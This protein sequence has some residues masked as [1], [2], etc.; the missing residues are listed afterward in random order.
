MEGQE[1]T[2]V[3]AGVM[4][5]DV[6]EAATRV[7]EVVR[8]TGRGG[9]SA[10]TRWTS[11]RARRARGAVEEPEGVLRAG[12]AVKIKAGEVETIAEEKV[13]AEMWGDLELLEL[14]VTGDV[15]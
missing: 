7:T 10:R 9:T 14:I 15:G 8:R 11:R 5:T 6:V 3:M 13:D 2:L 1:V 12:V 4:A